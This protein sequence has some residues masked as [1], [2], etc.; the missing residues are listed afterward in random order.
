MVYTLGC[1]GLF[2]IYFFT[3]KNEDLD[4]YSAFIFWFLIWFI[5]IF[6]GTLE[7]LSHTYYRPWKINKILNSSPL[8]EFKRKGFV[9]DDE[10]DLKGS[11]RGYNLFIGVLWENHEKQPSYFVQILF[12]PFS[13]DRFL[14]QDEYEKFEESLSEENKTFTL[15][16]LIIINVRYKGF[17]KAKYECIMRDIFEAIDFLKT[18][19]LNP[20]SFKEWFD[21]V[22]KLEKHIESFNY[23]N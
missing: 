14:R 18:R 2:L 23:D 12:N 5:L 8:V 13:N 16:S 10:N 9:K 3:N 4:V 15:N 17:K 22:P 7:L 19:K 21:N 6:I 20:I 1:L 11:I